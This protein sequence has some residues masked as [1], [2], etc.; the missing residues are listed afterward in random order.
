M[1]ALSLTVGQRI[2]FVLALLLLLWYVIGT[3][4]NRRRGI[5]TLN[6][7][8][9]GLDSLGGQVQASWIGSA[10]TGARLVINN[11]APPFRQLEVTFLLE[12]RELLPLWLV[13]LLRGRRDQ[14]IIKAHLHLPRKD[15][16]EVVPHGSRL[17]QSLRHEDRPSW[18]W[19]EGGP[20]SLRIAY[21]GGQRDVLM[22][23]VI[24]FLQSYG[25]FLHRFSWRKDKPH[26]LL[27]ARLAGLVDCSPTDFFDDLARVLAHSPDVPQQAMG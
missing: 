26:L 17:E 13:N 22:A 21:R 19:E 8:C 2:L 27:Q 16:M 12:S 14:L 4:Y 15:E 6:W 11:A 1:T 10:A 23:A 7:L 3:S 20:Y 5:R 24:P 9:E 18:Q 25:P